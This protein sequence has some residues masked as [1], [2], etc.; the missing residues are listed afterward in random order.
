MMSLYLDVPED[1]H[2]LSS[3][4]EGVLN[5]EDIDMEDFSQFPARRDTTLYEDDLRS[6]DSDDS[7][8]EQ[9]TSDLGTH[10]LD[11]DSL[12]EFEEELEIY[13]YWEEN[14]GVLDC[15]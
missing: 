8:V 9:D 5:P 3:T 13:D 7:N 15:R 14:N 11:E 2:D 6:Q 12:D 4:D 1:E 10:N